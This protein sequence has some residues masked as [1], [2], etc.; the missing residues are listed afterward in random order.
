MR[1]SIC[2]AASLLL[3]GCPAQDEIAHYQAPKSEPVAAVPQA[4]TAIT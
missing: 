3:T 4:P 2:L 1:A